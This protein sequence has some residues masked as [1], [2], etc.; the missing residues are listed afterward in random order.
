MPHVLSVLL[1]A[2]ALAGLATSASAD[3]PTITVALGMTPDQV[4]ERS[5]ASIPWSFIP[6]GTQR[7]GNALVT[8][9]HRLMYEDQSL[10][11]VFPDAGN[12]LSMPT[13]LTVTGDSLTFV[14]VSA[15]GDYVDVKTAVAESKRLLAVLQA[16]HFDYPSEDPSKGIHPKFLLARKNL[17][18]TPP[19]P[20]TV[21]SF[22]EM[23]A[24]F[25]N[26]A[27]YLEEFLVFRLR[28]GGIDVSLR[29]TNMRRRHTENQVSGK[30]PILSIPERAAQEARLID[31]GTLERERAYYLEVSIVRPLQPSTPR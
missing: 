27:F 13:S 17:L 4:R 2:L 5:T 26:S 20:R 19:P 25:L 1:L 12:Q 16:Q 15:L 18:S 11:L 23:E 21:S 14:S 28:R 31:R 7:A 8:T 6:V 9:P 3:K 10:R 30:G 24:A 29:A 22:E